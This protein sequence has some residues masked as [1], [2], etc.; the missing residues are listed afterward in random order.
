MPDPELPRK[1]SQEAK[2]P[3]PP[4]QGIQGEAAAA[5][6]NREREAR[7]RIIDAFGRIGLSY[8]QW[9]DFVQ[10]FYSDPLQRIEYRQFMM[11]S[12]FQAPDF[13]RLNQSPKDWVRVA[14]QAWEV[15]RKKF[16]QECEDWVSAGV[17]EPIAEVKCARGTGKKASARGGGRRRGGNTPMDRRYEWA[18]RYLL[19]VPLKEIAGADA[20]AT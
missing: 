1:P 14:D 8:R 10:A 7:L 16:L 9:P 17:D 18:A 19:K 6:K 5:G 3:E 15:H 2:Q 20:D 12:P 11:P 4:R 13:D